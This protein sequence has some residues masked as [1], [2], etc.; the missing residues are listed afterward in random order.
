MSKNFSSLFSTIFSSC[1][2]FVRTEEK[3]YKNFQ[4]ES[5][6]KI[7]KTSVNG[8]RDQNNLLT[9]IIV[10]R[11]REGSKQIRKTFFNSAATV[12]RYTLTPTRE[13]Y[14]T[15]NFLENF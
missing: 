9:L 5:W 13:S 6:M 10:R 11:E 1:S 3:K 14:H 12:H 15:T 7:K 2:L 8:K 4:N